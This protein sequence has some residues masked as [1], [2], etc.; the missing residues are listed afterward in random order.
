MADGVGGDQLLEESL[1][2]FE[3]TVQAARR[4]SMTRGMDLRDGIIRQLT[5][6]AGKAR[7][8]IADDEHYGD[9][10]IAAATATAQADQRLRS[11]R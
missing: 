5:G 1:E 8:S 4:M 2:D 10:L 6:I 7:D 9:L 11:E 3:A